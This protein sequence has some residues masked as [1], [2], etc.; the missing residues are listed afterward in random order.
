MPEKWKGKTGGTLWMQRSLIS[1]LHVVPLPLLYLFTEIF[2][3]PFYLIF[4][5]R[6]TLAIYH[7]YRRHLKL[8]QWKSFFMAYRNECR[9]SQIILD[10]FY[11]YSGKQMNFD[12][13]GYAIYQHLSREKEGFVILSAHIGNYEAAGYELNARDKRFNVLVYGGESSTVMENRQKLMQGNNINMILTGDDSSHLFEI[14]KALSNGESLSIPGDRNFGS[15]RSITCPFMGSLA[16]FPL[17]PFIIAAQREV[18]VVTIHV[19]KRNTHRYH[20]Y[21]RQLKS[22]GNTLYQRAETLARE[23]ADFLEKTVRKY[24]DQWFNY[25]EFWK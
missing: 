18:P 9:F 22:D 10:R 2:V 21:I 5:Q 7:F 15:T 1:M 4:S 23:Y 11:I 8:P 16:E 17:G 20:I 13:E 24:P 12:I 19:M 14:N 25:Y 3:I 6:S